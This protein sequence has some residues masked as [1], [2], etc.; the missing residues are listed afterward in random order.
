MIL[1]RSRET[2]E[3]RKHSDGTDF[4]C[5]AFRWTFQV[6]KT[7]FGFAHQF[8][9]RD[10]GEWRTSHTSVYEICFTGQF[11]FGLC[12]MYYDGPHC[13]FQ[14]GWIM[15]CWGGNPFK[16]GSCKKCMADGFGE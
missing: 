6:A 4:P 5:S 8:K 9:S 11:G 3:V 2:L 14:V 13:S 12:H 7:G 16:G 10:T 15:F 1:W